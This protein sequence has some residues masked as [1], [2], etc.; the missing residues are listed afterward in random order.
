[1]GGNWIKE[2]TV[3]LRDIIKDGHME[4]YLEL[5]QKFFLMEIN[6]W[7]Y[8]QLTRFVQKL[9]PPLRSEE[10][11]TEMEKLCSTEST[12]GT[13]SKVY[14]IL[15]EKDEREIPPFIEKWEREFKTQ[16]DRTQLCLLYTSPSP[17]D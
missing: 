10:Q 3:K 12:K 17:R 7:R 14:R 1:M 5:K 13:I 15:L 11:L 16:H 2:D 8:Q 6:E 9:P 4:T